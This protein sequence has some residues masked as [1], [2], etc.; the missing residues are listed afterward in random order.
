MRTAETRPIRRPGI[1]LASM[2]FWAL[3][4]AVLHTQLVLAAGHIV[5]ATQLE[6]PIL[7]PTL[8]PST[9]ISEILYGNV[10]EGLVQFGADGVVLPKLASTW[11]ISADAHIA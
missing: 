3:L 2:S 1:R 8:S 9:A 10:Y 6:P 11:E 5:I 7:D 4:L